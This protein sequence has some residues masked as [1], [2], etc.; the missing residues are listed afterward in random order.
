MFMFSILS[1]EELILG[2]FGHEMVNILLKKVFEA[3][4]HH[5]LSEKITS[6]NQLMTSL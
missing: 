1:Q 2:R 4:G 5:F 3:K 6:P